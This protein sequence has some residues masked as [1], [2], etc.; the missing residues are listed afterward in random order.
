MGI[1]YCQ[2]HSFVSNPNK[3]TLYIKPLSSLEVVCLAAGNMEKTISLAYAWLQCPGTTETNKHKR[4]WENALNTTFSNDQWLN[5]CIFAHKCSMS[6]RHQETSYKFLTNWYNTTSKIHKWFPMLSNLCWRCGEAEGSACHIW[7]DCDPIRPFWQKV[8]ETIKQ[9]TETS[10]TLMA[11]CCLLSI[12]KGTM[13]RYKSSLTRFL[14]T[15]AKVLIPRYWK[16][17]K[18]HT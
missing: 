3:R 1:L 9:I 7:W 2:I 18:I 6:T 16:T 15:A 11:A 8:C 10:I 5:A 4:F 12:S 17:T 14:L 13:K